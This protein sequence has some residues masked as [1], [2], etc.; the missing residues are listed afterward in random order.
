MTSPGPKFTDHRLPCRTDFEK[1]SPATEAELLFNLC[2]CIRHHQTSVDMIA[3]VAAHMCEW[4][5]GQ[6]WQQYFAPGW[7]AASGAGIR[8]LDAL[9]CR[10]LLTLPG[11][12]VVHAQRP[13]RRAPHQWF[14]VHQIDHLYR[15]CGRRHAQGALA[16]YP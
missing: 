8:R 1:N 15:C 5:D 16:A 11:I 4:D 2:L 13:L 6:A 9:Q 7:A 10:Q 3:R 14:L 12:A